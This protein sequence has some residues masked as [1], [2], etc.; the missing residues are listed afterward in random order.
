[1]FIAAIHV[2]TT[3]RMV[4]YTLCHYFWGQHCCWT[5]T[6]ILVRNVLFFISLNFHWILLLTPAPTLLRLLHVFYVISPV[7][8]LSPQTWLSKFR[9]QKCQSKTSHRESLALDIFYVKKMWYI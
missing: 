9:S 5:E 8:W 2:P 4:F 3:L 7:N 6:N 1:M